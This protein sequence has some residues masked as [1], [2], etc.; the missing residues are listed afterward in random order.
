MILKK[1]LKKENPSFHYCTI[2]GL[3][4]GGVVCLCCVFTVIFQSNIWH[5]RNFII[6]LQ[7]SF[8][9][10]ISYHISKPSEL[11]KVSKI[12]H[13]FPCIYIFVCYFI[14]PKL[15]FSTGTSGIFLCGQGIKGVIRFESLQ[16]TRQLVRVK[17]GQSTQ[18]SCLQLRITSSFPIACY[19]NSICAMI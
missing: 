15:S 19:K 11:L 2:L 16:L 13:A 12:F 14:C 3:N 7:N 10:I 18:G 9:N 5:L 17:N 1:K 8:S 6:R 4:F